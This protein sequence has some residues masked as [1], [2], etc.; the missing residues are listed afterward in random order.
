MGTF[1][2]GCAPAL[3]A[4]SMWQGEETMYF[5]LASSGTALV[6]RF[7]VVRGR[8]EERAHIVP[9]MYEEAWCAQNRPGLGMSGT[10]ENITA[11]VGNWAGQAAKTRSSEPF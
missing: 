9:H 6:M 8:R 1:W 5:S 3:I 2:A 7:R 11:M 4:L 10:E